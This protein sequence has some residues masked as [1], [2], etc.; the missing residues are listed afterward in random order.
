MGDRGLIVA[1]DIRG[2]R[3]DLL[4]HTVRMA[5]AASVRVVRADVTVPL[6]YDACFDWILLDAPCSGLGTIRRDP[7][8]RWRRPESDL[9]DLGASQR[10]MIEETTRVLRPGGHV[11][12]STCSSEP[13][14]NEAVV[15]AAVRDRL[16]QP[17][18]LTHLSEPMRPLIND[19]GHLRTLPFAHGLEAF[20]AALLVKPA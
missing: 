15:A 1:T 6:P 16:V 18:E 11:V 4:T 17:V 14:E 19:A 5:G 3:L 20:F 13:E 2:K 8:I 9:P 7:D 12:Y 10:R